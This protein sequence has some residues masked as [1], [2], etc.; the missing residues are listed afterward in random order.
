MMN[1]LTSEKIQQLQRRRELLA[2]QRRF[3]GQREKFGDTLV[4]ALGPIVGGCLSLAD[5]DPGKEPPFLVHVSAD[6]SVSRGFIAAYIDKYRALEIA[7]CVATAVGSAGFLG[8]LGNGY[9]GLAHVATAAI[10][11]LVDAC[12]EINDSVVFYPDG[13]EG[14][15]VFD[16]YRSSAPS[17]PFSVIVQGFALE[18]AL[19]G[20]F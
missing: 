6:V 16:C 2:R 5:F 8:I 20:C 19:A 4:K 17:E 11:A 1:G 12:E 7:R 15:I 14:A 3:A 10:P 13:S 18:A 9:L